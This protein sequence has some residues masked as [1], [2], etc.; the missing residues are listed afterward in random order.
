MPVSKAINLSIF[1]DEEKLK[2]L[3]NLCMLAASRRDS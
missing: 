2:L 3:S 1:T